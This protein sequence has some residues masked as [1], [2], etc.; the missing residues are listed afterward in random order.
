M[1]MRCWQRLQTAGTK[2]LARRLKD[3]EWFQ[4]RFTLT[5]SVLLVSGG[6]GADCSCAVPGHSSYIFFLTKPML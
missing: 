5:P 2:H 3:G 6:V 1:G 4:A